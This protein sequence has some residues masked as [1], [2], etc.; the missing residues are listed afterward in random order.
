M[1]SVNNKY[2][3]LGSGNWTMGVFASHEHNMSKLAWQ[4]GVQI[5]GWDSLVKQFKGR[6]MSE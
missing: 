5:K 2:A 3:L 4:P 1:V 6:A